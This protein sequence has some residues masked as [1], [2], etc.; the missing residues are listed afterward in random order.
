M[1][2]NRLRKLKVINERKD[3]CI[4]VCQRG[5]IAGG[6][7]CT[8]IR[9]KKHKFWCWALVVCLVMTIYTGYKHK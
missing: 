5:Y 8:G 6:A 3:K 9:M 4:S 7:V 1:Y 2:I